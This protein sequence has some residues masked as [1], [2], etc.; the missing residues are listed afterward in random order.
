MK[1]LVATVAAATCLAGI[2]ALTGASGAHAS[3]THYITY[4]KYD[5]YMSKCKAF[6]STIRQ[7]PGYHIVLSCTRLGTSGSQLTY[8][9]G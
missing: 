9:I 2:G 4:W 5:P 8:G 6:Q 1:R 7:Q 3:G